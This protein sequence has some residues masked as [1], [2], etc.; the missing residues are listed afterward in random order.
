LTVTYH[1][2]PRVLR[3][4][5]SGLEMLTCIAMTASY[6]VTVH[7]PVTE[8]PDNWPTIDK[9]MQDNGF[10]FAVD[11]ADGR[12]LQLNNQATYQGD[13]ANAEAELQKHVQAHLKSRGLPLLEVEVIRLRAVIGS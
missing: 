2:R 7:L 10:T 3:D 6:L 11:K 1:G 9:A 13:S 8:H 12:R 5:P 4:S